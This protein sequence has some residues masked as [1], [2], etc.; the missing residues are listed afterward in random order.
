MTLGNSA[1]LIVSI[2]VIFMKGFHFLDNFMI[3]GG[4]VRF[5]ILPRTKGAVQTV[6][7]PP[8]RLKWHMLRRRKSDA[9][10]L[11]ENLVAALKDGAA[12]EV[13][14]GARVDAWTIDADLPDLRDVLRR[15]IAVGCH[16]LTSNDPEALRPIVEEVALCS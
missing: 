11:R 2:L 14:A 13:G 4:A 15:L 3:L 7:L 9:P 10:F 1:R 16:Q 12:C 6:R 8:S 5:S